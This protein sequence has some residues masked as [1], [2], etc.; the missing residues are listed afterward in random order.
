MGVEVPATVTGAGVENPAL[1]PAL[2][3]SKEPSLAHPDRSREEGPQAC[4]RG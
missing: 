3:A 1:G 4:L 2:T